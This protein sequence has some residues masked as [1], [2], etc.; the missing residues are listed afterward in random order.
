MKK[1]LLINSNTEKLPYPV[2][3]LG[4]CLAAASL[5]G[6]YD[7]MIYDGAFD[8]GAALPGIVS[9]YRPDYVGLSLRN[10]DDMNIL[11][12]AD[13]IGLVREKFIEPLRGLTAAPL[14]LGGSGF[15]IFPEY[16]VRYFGA[17]Y[18]VVGEG[19]AVLPRLI[20]TLDGGGDPS[21]MPGVVSTRVSGYRPNHDCIDMKNLP[22][23]EIDRKIDFAPYRQRGSYPIQT[24]RGC[25]HNC[26]YC[27][28]N[29]IEGNV[30]RTRPA[31][32]IA[33]EIEEAA[34]RLGAVTFEFVDS[35]FNDPAGHA[36]A[37]CREIARRGLGVRLRTMG[38]NPCNVTPQLFE[39]MRSAG[40]AQIDCTPDTASAAMLR[41]MGKNFSKEQL[42]VAAATVRDFDFPT[43]WFFIFGGPGETEDT[44]HETFQFIDENISGRDMVHMTFGLRIY[45]GTPLRKRAIEEGMI[46]AGDPLVEPRFYISRELGRERL[47]EVVDE[48]ARTRPNCV[49]V[50]ET[51]P[52]AE[53]MREAARL[54]SDG[55]PDEPMFRTLL[56]L[57]YRM[58]GREMPQ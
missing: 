52:S 31:A 14:I 56:R 19:E 45:P 35:T 15:S 47:M 5:Q 39:L 54:R 24:K 2:P 40:F 42:R 18:G 17:D 7:V 51:A 46:D 21:A 37:I 48:A 41:T 32:H 29:C 58:M 3:P 20:A 55:L 4:L 28:Y 38:I 34:E 22:Y 33:G 49:P 50:T 57:R 43:M 23:A 25:A 13:Y 1:I 8:S 6:E 27:T 44:I 9:D 36:E 53:M 12:P 26:V 30:Y 16:L 11:K 10:I